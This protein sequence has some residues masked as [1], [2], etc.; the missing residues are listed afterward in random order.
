LYDPNKLVWDKWSSYENY[1]P[2]VRSL[3]EL[4]TILRGIL[5]FEITKDMPYPEYIDPYG[6]YMAQKRMEDY[7]QNVFD[8]LHL[9]KNK[10]MK[11]ADDEYIKLWGDDKVIIKENSNKVLNQKE[12]Y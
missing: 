11:L 3:L 4:Q 1:C 5:S 7:I 12:H 6:D 9:G 8:N 10:S 2:K